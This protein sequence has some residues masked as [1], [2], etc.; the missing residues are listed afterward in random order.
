LAVAKQQG[1]D[2]AMADKV[3]YYWS[4][5]LPDHQ[6][7]ALRLAD[8]LMTQPGSIDQ[9][10]RDELHRHFTHDQL[11]ELTVDVMKWNYQKVPVALGTD[12]EVKPGELADL[13]FDERGHF[14]R[15]T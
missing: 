12:Y 14:V 10:L 2:E 6:K 13:V 5:D 11:I 15:P 7:A 4:S 1:L 9:E 3:D 8:A